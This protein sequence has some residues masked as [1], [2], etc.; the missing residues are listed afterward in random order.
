[1]N[2]K[3]RER[4]LSQIEH[5]RIAIALLA[6]D[7][8]IVNPD[9]KKIAQKLRKIE[10]RA[11][12]G[13]LDLCNGEMNQSGWTL[14]SRTVTQEVRDLFNN[15]IPGFFVNSDPRGYALKIREDEQRKLEERGIKLS[16]DWGG[17]GLLAP[18]FNGN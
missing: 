3:E 9:G 5:H 13:A 8:G 4:M 6:S 7:C 18:E 16:K 10:E 1:M 14:L 11:S 2:K 17:Y 15:K 12:R